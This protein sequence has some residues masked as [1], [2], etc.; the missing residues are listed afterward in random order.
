[1]LRTRLC[2]LLGIEFPIICAPMGFVTG[3]ELAAAVSNAGGLGIMSFSGNPPEALRQE[4][5]RLREMTDKPFGVNLL[6][7]YPVE[8]HI[9]VCLEEC[10]P[11]LSFFWGDPSPYVESAHAA[12]IKVF[13]QIGSVEAAQKAVKAGVDVIIAQ[14]VEAGGHI[15]GEVTT[16]A[17]VP[18]VVEAVSPTPVVASGGIAD[19]RGL[20]AALALGAEAVA[21]GTLYLAATES[22][23]HSI[24]KQKVLAASEKDTVR[25]T[26]FGHGWPNAPDRTLRTPFVEEWLSQEERGNESRP[27]EP[28]IGETR[29]AGEPVPVQR[30]RGFPPSKDVT[31]D[32][33]SMN[34]LMGQGVGLVHEIKPAAT[35]VKELVEGAQQIIRERLNG[36]LT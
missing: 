20:V 22:N 1:M 4:I 14:G 15:E 11:I 12:G 35:I 6:L 2:D 3:P 17:I 9:A 16:L 13:H 36:F 18:R 28:I 26:L 23:S 32:I 34:F 19:A 7:H 30:F 8:D 27:D 29:I 21:I 24:Y 33:E 5:R 31:G 10:I 25:T